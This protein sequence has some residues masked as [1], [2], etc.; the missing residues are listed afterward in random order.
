MYTH[1][2]PINIFIYHIHV[3]S[4]HIQIVKNTRHT[5]TSFRSSLN[6]SFSGFEGRCHVSSFSLCLLCTS[7]YTCILHDP[8]ICDMTRSFRFSLPFRCT[9]IYDAWGDNMTHGGDK[10]TPRVQYVAKMRLVLN[11]N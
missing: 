8:F 1:I 4:Y 11:F 5:I 9:H 10:C 3:L 7:L 6:L 2:S